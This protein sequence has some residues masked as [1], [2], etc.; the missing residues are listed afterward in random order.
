ME[1]KAL[2]DQEQ[3]YWIDQQDADED[4]TDRLLILLKLHHPGEEHS[5]TVKLRPSRH[6]PVKRPAGTPPF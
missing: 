4:A 2:T 5:R 3:Q 6:V 1:I